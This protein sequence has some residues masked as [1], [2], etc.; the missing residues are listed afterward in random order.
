MN[1]KH[2]LFICLSLFSGDL[3]LAATVTNINGKNI[4]LSLDLDDQLLVGKNLYLLNSENKKI[5]IIKVTA[6]TNDA[7][8]AFLLKGNANVGATAR[9]FPSRISAPSNIH[10]AKNHFNITL[11]FNSNSLKAFDRQGNP[12]NVSGQSLNFGFSYES[13]LDAGFKARYGFEYNDFSVSGGDATLKRDLKVGYL[14]LRSD[15]NYYLNPSLFA[16]LGLSFM[17]PMSKSSTNLFSKDDINSN[18][19]VIFDFGYWIQINSGAIPL[20]LQY[21]YFLANR[22]VST[23]M[24]GLQTGFSW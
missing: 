3:L 15:I 1:L 13:H 20:T 23:S 9:S 11:G 12:I 10:L 7:A 8:S 6:T 19:A 16:G 2:L 5:G 18:L 24:L 4:K 22:D 17:Y 14:G 21:Y